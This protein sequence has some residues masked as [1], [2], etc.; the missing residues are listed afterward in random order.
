MMASTTARCVEPRSPP[1]A[2]IL[3]PT[4]SF[5][6]TSERQAEATLSLPVTAITSRSTIGWTRAGSTV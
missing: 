1:V 4:M 5:G 6:S 3:M 2:L